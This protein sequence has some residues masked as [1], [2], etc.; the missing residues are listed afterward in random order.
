MEEIKKTLIE[1][2]NEEL[3]KCKDKKIVPSK[4]VLD[5]IETINQLNNL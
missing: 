1:I 3:K 5:T 2:A 4:E